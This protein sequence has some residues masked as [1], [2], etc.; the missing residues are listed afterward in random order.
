MKFMVAWGSKSRQWL[1]FAALESGGWMTAYKQVSGTGC[2]GDSRGRLA[3]DGLGAL[4][5][6]SNSALSLNDPQL[7]R[8]SC[9][10]WAISW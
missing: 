9:W 4:E 3:R 2:F 6:G 5:R 8:T 7:G 10:N 1:G